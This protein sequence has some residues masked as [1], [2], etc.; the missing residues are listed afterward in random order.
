MSELIKLYTFN[1]CSGW[2]VNYNSIKLFLKIR[3]YLLKKNKN[4]SIQR[5]V[6]KCSSHCSQ[7]PNI[8]NNIHVHQLVDG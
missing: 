3:L 8:G 2:V 4:K 5:L 7:S 1:L 6:N